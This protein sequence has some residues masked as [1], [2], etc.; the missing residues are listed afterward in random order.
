[1]AKMTGLGKGLEALFTINNVEPVKEDIQKGEIIQ[2]LKLI[3]VEPNKNQPRVQ[4]DSEKIDEL[5][6]QYGNEN[7]ESLKKNENVRHYMNEKLLQENT[8]NVVLDNVVIK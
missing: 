7:A 4:F 3:D 6:T 8:L 2:N 1:M 5:A